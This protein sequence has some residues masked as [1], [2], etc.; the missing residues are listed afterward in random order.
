MLFLVYLLLETRVLQSEFF[1]CLRGG[2][3]A[4]VEA[5]CFLVLV[6]KTGF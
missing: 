2:G 6:V 4:V 1:H 3:Q 5:L